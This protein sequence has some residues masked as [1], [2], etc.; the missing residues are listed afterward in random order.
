MKR[1]LLPY[2]IIV[3][4]TLAMFYY[5]RISSTSNNKVQFNQ[6]TTTHFISNQEVSQYGGASSVTQY[7]TTLDINA[8]QLNQSHYLTISGTEGLSGE[9][10]LDGRVLTTFGA[11]G[12]SIDLAPYLSRGRHSITLAG[13]ARGSIKM[14]FTGPGIN[15]TH[16]ASSGWMDIE[17]TLE[18]W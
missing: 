10:C 4:A 14:T 3:T 2:I 9:L 18:V 15:L 1:Q 12:T 6:A 7:Q 8:K 16:Q 13:P 5:S 11:N 17:L